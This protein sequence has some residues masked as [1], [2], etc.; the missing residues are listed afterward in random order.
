MKIQSVLLYL[1]RYCSSCSTFISCQRMTENK[2]S[3][4]FIANIMKISASCDL[5]SVENVGGVGL[6]S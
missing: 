6:N 3:I 5:D 2:S 4:L 1:R